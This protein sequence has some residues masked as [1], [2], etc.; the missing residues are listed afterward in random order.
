M[1]YITNDRRA[2]MDTKKLVVGQEVRIHSGC[3]YEN[4]KVLEVTLS[5]VEVHILDG[6]RF[7]FDTLG[8]GCDGN[9]TYECGPWEIVEIS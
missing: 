3:Y 2:M 5:G 6:R 8:N 4:G 9:A 7:R 1:A